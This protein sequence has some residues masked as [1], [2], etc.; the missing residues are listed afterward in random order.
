MDIL[1]Q[2]EAGQL[3]GTEASSSEGQPDGQFTIDP[4]VIEEHIRENLDDDQEKSLDKLLDEGKELL[5]GEE[6]HYQLLK[7]LEQS[8]DLGKDLG[9]GAYGMILMLV[10]QGADL[11]GE[12]VP[13]AAAI[14][15]SRVADFLNQ[16]QMVQVTDDDVSNAIETFGHL[17]MQHDPQYMGRM[18]QSLG[19]AGAMQQPQEQ[20]AQPILQPG[21]LLNTT[22]V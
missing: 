12:V 15:I 3:A 9:E 8:Q 22:G 14:L 20:Q 21:G 5:F 7:G 16:A 11:S 1:P 10:K 6:S 17:I 19:Q 13:S 2:E 18:K 4:A